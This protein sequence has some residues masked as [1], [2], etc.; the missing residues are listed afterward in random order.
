M[1][2]EQFRQAY[3]QSKLSLSYDNSEESLVY[4]KHNSCSIWRY[5]FDK[6]RLVARGYLVQEMGFW[7]Y[8]ETNFEETRVTED[9]I[10]DDQFNLIGVRIRTKKPIYNSQGELAAVKETWIDKMNQN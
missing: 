5:R 1:T 4:L 3:E 8:S 10:L 6:E 2:S 9:A 7:S